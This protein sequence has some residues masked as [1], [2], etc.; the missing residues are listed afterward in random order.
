[1]VGLKPEAGG[2][3]SGAARHEEFVERDAARS[4]RRA[5]GKHAVASHRVRWHRGTSHRCT[6][7]R[8]HEPGPQGFAEKSRSTR[9]YLYLLIFAVFAPAAWRRAKGW[10]VSTNVT[11]AGRS[12]EPRNLRMQTRA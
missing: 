1:M 10:D 2:S 7:H 5:A 11:I 8:A 6:W 9:T 3:M 4:K 12:C